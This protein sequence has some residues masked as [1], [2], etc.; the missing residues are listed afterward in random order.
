M[1]GNDMLEQDLQA[2]SQ[3]LDLWKSENPIKTTKLQLLLVVNA[4]L[5]TVVQHNGGV[6]QKNIPIFFCGAVLCLAWT[7]SIGRTDLYQS[8][9]KIKMN[10]L[11]DKHPDDSRFQVVVT[12]DVYSSA[13]RWLRAIGF[14]SSKVFLPAVPIVFTLVWVVIG[15]FAL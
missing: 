13:P 4:A 1:A 11:A 5:V 9:W 8:L 6:V 15:L 10:Q 2:Y 12:K 14:S 3:L 7:L